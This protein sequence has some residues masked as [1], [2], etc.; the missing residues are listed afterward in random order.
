[1]H[2]QLI[3]ICSF[4]RALR[5]SAEGLGESTT[6]VTELA[7]GMRAGVD[8]SACLEF[9]T[10]LFSIAFSKV[11][12]A[13]CPRMLDCPLLAVASLS[14]LITF[15]REAMGIGVIVLAL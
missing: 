3:H 10:A 15:E 6:R 5:D 4:R 12:M 14:A 1:M 9:S 13:S 11:S 8:A 7:S 2:F